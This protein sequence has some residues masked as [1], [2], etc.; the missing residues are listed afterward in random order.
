MTCSTRC[1]FIATAAAAL[2]IGLTGR[3]ILAVA[4]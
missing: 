3:L 1:L 4:G 2:V